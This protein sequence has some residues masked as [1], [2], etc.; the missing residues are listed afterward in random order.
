MSE[1][2]KAANYCLAKGWWVFPLGVKSKL[3]HPRLSPN[4]VKNASNDPRQIAEWWEQEPNANYGVACGPS[5]LTV[6]DLDTGL[7][8]LDD[9]RAWVTKLQ[10][11]NTFVVRTGRRTSCGLQLYFSGTVPNKPFKHEGVG[12]EIRSAGYYV[13]GAKSIHPDSG[14]PY[15]ILREI[16]PAPIP[17]LIYHLVGI[18]TPRPTGEDTEL[19]APSQ[20]HYYLVERGRELFFAGLDGDGLKQAMISLY[21]TRCK[22][23]PAKNARIPKEVEDI[24]YWIKK[25]PPIFPLQPGDFRTIRYA[26]KDPK[27]KAAYDC[28]L[29][30][31]DG[32]REKAFDYLTLSLRSLGA[33]VDQIK[34]IIGSSPLGFT[35]SDAPSYVND[36]SSN[37]N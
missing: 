26:E 7:P 17:G 27:V 16:A 9:A 32:N 8:T 5:G 35:E 29:E 23:D 37:F 6:M 18:K 13:A 22:H 20:R 36:D 28:Q 2:I 12:G 30:L 33:N 11:P 10:L 1:I 24:I 25:N 15:E 34:R 3:P 19:I 4:G 14:E 21:T 31:F